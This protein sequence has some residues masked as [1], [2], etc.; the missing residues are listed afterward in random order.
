MNFAHLRVHS[1]ALPRAWQSFTSGE[2]VVLGED[3]QLSDP[4]VLKLARRAR[5]DPDDPPNE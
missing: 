1:R 2:D 4:H 3:N 5:L